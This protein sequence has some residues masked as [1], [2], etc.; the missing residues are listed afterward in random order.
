MLYFIC[1]TNALL[2]FIFSSAVMSPKKSPELSQKGVEQEIAHL[3]GETSQPKSQTSSD[4]Q[5]LTGM[6]AKFFKLQ[7]VQHTQLMKVITDS[8][9]SSQQAV[10]QV[11]NKV[12]PSLPPQQTPSATA[13]PSLPQ[14][15][16]AQ[17]SYAPEEGWEEVEG[18]NDRPESDEEYDDDDA[19]DFPSS[20]KISAP[21]SKDAPSTSAATS[22]SP[23]T[24]TLDSELFN[25]YGLTVNWALAPEL[26]SWLKSSAN[27]EVPYAILKQLNESFVPVEE[28]QPLF[29]APALPTT[30]SKL[31][32]TAPKSV[33][34]GP[35]I[36]NSSL[37]R[38][39]REL[40]IGYKPLLE[41]LNFF[42]SESCSSLIAIIPDLKDIFTRQKLLLSQCLATLLSASLRVSKAR[43]TALRPIVRYRSSSILQHQPTSQ[44]VL[45]SGDLAALAD[46][47]NK[48]NKALSGIFFRQAGRPR[49][50]YRAQYQPYNRNFSRSTQYRRFPTGQS[51]YRPSNYRQYQNSKQKK[52][53]ANSSTNK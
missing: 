38:V 5:E 41:V 33:S 2:I 35:K 27:K 10:S 4:L 12:I 23:D 26:T 24:E 14:V 46:K 3:A 49:G 1:E 51:S 8:S 19:W 44:H 22:A 52:G 42:Y 47:A 28:L 53:V 16:F 36:L 11:V 37:L 29:T 31:L 30:I 43:K 20:G 21:P 32:Y 6:F 7:E 15:N 48:E 25:M 9:H 18:D 40:C 17:D 45:G 39:Q 50:R 13:C 34:R